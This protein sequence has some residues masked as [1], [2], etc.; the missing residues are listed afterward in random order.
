MS[1]I[2][3]FTPPNP[4]SADTEY[5]RWKP[6]EHL[7][8]I[9]LFA[10]CHKEMKKRTLNGREMMGEVVVADAVVL[11]NP[12]GSTLDYFSN[13]FVFN[14]R[15]CAQLPEGSSTYGKLVMGEK[16]SPNARPYVVDATMTAED[17]AAV[18]AW[19]TA[20]QWTVDASGA[21]TVGIEPVVAPTQPVV[22]P[23]PPA[24][25]APVVAPVVPQPP[26][27][28]VPATAPV[29]APPPVEVPPVHQPAPIPA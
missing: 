5:R 8:R 6:E 15:I 11:I 1:M 14:E 12:D 24:P 4:A 16:R 7:N 29:P 28:P 9:H 21:I 2:T 3:G 25:P 26:A 19:M 27:P 10:N 17:H 13:V 20:H 18:S 22:A 23:A